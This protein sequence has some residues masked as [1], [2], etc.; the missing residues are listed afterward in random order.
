MFLRRNTQSCTILKI[1][2]ILSFILLAFISISNAETTNIYNDVANENTTDRSNTSN[3]TNRE[4]DLLDNEEEEDD[5]DP[6]SNN[7]QTS[8]NSSTSNSTY[9]PNARVST[10]SSIPEANLGLNNVLCVIL[11]AIGILLI[12]L[13]IAILIRIKN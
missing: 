2:I 3:T 8:T 9:N 12:L 6:I 7:S 10:V 4:D 11:I 13:A 1:S 5:I